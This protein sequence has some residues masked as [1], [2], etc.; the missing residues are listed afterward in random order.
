MDE[1]PHNLV[2]IKIARKIL[3]IGKAMQIL[4]AEEGLLSKS[5][6]SIQSHLKRLTTHIPIKF[7]KSITQ[8]HS[9]ISNRFMELII[10][11]ENMREE[12]QA[13][14][15]IYLLKDE[16]FYKTFIEESISLISMMPTKHAEQE[17]NHNCYLNALIRLN[18]IPN[19]CPWKNLKYIL[20][21]KGFFYEKF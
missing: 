13:I 5:L 18:Y 19:E 12:I 21:S 9:I 20:K 17:I 7:D 1:I 15:N 2:N 3:F 8:I 11:K 16:L 10:L 4:I 14:M 6:S